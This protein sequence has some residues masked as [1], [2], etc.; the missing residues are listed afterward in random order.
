MPKRLAFRTRSRAR[1]PEA[2]D[3]GRSARFREDPHDRFWWHKLAAT[4]YV[5]ALYAS[6]R[7]DEWA[8]MQGWYEE[9]GR[10]ARI[11]EINVPAM[12]LATGLIG[13]SG[14]RRIVQL[15]HYYGY[16]ALLLGFTLRTMGARPGLVTVDIDPAACEFTR[17]WL[18]H[19]GLCDHVVVREGDSADPGPADDAAAVLGGPPEL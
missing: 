4:D 13:G 6:L 5:P 1:V 17:R 9:T 2:P 7:E 19:A 16:S 12:S 11:A 3:P 10:I 18:A 14:V 8:V 15:G